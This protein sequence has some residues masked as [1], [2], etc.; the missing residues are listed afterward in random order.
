MKLFTAA[1]AIVA[2]ANA[3]NEVTEEKGR[4]AHAKVQSGVTDDQ[5]LFENLNDKWCFSATPPMVKIGWEFAQSWTSTPSTESP[6]VDY[7][8]W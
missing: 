3:T 7:Y 8:Q 5:C 2:L 1:L 4:K 6:V